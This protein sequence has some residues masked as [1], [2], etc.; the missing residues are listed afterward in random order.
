MKTAVTVQLD[1]TS[2]A[3]EERAFL[4]LRAYLDRAAA[5]LGNHPDRSDVLAG[6]ERSIAGKLAARVA[7]PAAPC[8]ERAMLVALREVGRVDGPDL[9]APDSGGGDDR[10]RS[11]RLYRLRQGQLVAGVCTGLAAFAEI[12]VNIVRLLFVVGALFTGG[13][14]LAAYIVLVFVMPVAY[15]EDERAAAHGGTQSGGSR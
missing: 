5:R 14:L 15:P 1:G 2:F 7:E 4:A 9:G 13:L 6:L 12:D 11:R 10:W 8:D 3:L